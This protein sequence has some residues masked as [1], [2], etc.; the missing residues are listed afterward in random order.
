MFLDASQ[1]GLTEELVSI[2]GVNGFESPGPSF[3][4]WAVRSWAEA[5][6]GRVTVAVVAKH[7]HA[8]P[9]KIGLLIAAE[10]GLN[11]NIDTSEDDANAWLNTGCR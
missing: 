3:R 1:H 4:R 7:K 6:A 8:W 2:K 9:H 11:A 5:V 10:E